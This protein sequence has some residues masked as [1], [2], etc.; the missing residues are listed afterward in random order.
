MSAPD[1]DR[2]EWQPSLLALRA[3]AEDRFER[4]VRNLIALP[5][6]VTATDVPAAL[7]ELTA[8]ETGPSL[9][10]YLFRHATL[11]QTVA[12]IDCGP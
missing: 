8:A 12:H 2:W 6:A 9:A 3:V 11:D 10:K 7:V 1:R 4:A 5:A